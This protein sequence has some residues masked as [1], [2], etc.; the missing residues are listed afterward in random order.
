MFRLPAFLALLMMF[1]SACNHFPSK[2]DRRI[3]QSRLDLGTSHLNKG[4]FR[5]ALN[6]LLESEKLNPDSAQLQYSLGLTYFQGFGRGDDAR[7]HLKR[8][9]ELKEH[10]SEAANLYG[11]TLMQEQRFAEAVPYFRQALDNL[12]Y[13][14]PEFARQNLGWAL[15]NSGQTKD[16]IQTLEIAVRNA[17]TLC[18]GYY[19]LGL[20]NGKINDDVKARHWFETY[21]RK[22]DGTELSKF[23]AVDSL[24][25][26]L[27]RLGLNL[28]KSGDL[29]QAKAYFAD[30]V[31]RGKESAR[32]VDCQKSLE[33]MP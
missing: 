29:K 4:E 12:L 8:A 19:W 11:V 32:V 27:Y 16:G 20:A 13:G 17:P 9:L 33:V 21:L 15:V 30:C 18:G 31:Q 24:V 3:A 5:Q 7:K 23:V 2:K 6:E 1:T 25:D 10:Y 22:C 14:T 26:V 28:Q